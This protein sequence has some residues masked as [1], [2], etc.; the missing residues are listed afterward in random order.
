MAMIKGLLQKKKNYYNDLKSKVKYEAN[1]RINEEKFVLKQLKYQQPSKL[2]EKLNKVSRYGSIDVTEMPP[3]KSFDY[4]KDLNPMYMQGRDV[5]GERSS[6][7][8][9]KLQYYANKSP[10]TRLHVNLPREELEPND[11]DDSLDREEKAEFLVKKI[12]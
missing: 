11:S 8:I 6:S 1:E 12:I 4:G 10:F 9:D 2:Q 5:I 7:Q 3:R